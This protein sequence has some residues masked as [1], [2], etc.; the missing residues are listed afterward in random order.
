MECV[1]VAGRIRWHKISWFDM[2][3]SVVIKLSVLSDLSDIYTFGP[4]LNVN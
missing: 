2:W 3:Y 1:Q 4:T